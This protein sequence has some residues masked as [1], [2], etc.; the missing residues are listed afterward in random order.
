[1]QHGEDQRRRQQRT[2]A[3]D[4]Q[5]HQ[6]G[7]GAGTENRFGHTAAEGR[8]DTLLRRFLHEHQDDYEQRDQYVYRRQKSDKKSHINYL[9][10]FRLNGRLYNAALTISAKP[11]ASKL[12]PPTSAPSM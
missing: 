9:Y 12:A 10:S 2:R 6:R 11:F 4:R 1:M 5:A 3:P 7:G 8:S